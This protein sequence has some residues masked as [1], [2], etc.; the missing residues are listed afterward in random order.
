MNLYEMK[1]KDTICYVDDSK[2][3]GPILFTFDGI[4]FFNF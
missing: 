3:E 1:D 2:S 4:E